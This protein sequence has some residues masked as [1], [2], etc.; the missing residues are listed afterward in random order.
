M[1]IPREKQKTE[2]QVNRN[3]Q[4][5]NI[6]FIFVLAVFSCSDSDFKS[7][8]LLH[9][10]Q[11]KWKRKNHLEAEILIKNDSIFYLQD[12]IILS[13]KDKIIAKGQD[14]LILLDKKHSLT[15]KL[16]E[17]NNDLMILKNTNTNA[18]DTL[19]KVID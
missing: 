16:L 6:C 12:P 18:F 1:R 11:G 10:I 8:D 13:S 9:K 19:S 3:N 4:M 7:G 17:V 15:V 14:T 2:V 5:K